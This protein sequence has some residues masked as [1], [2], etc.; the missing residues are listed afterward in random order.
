[1][2][3]E[4]LLQLVQILEIFDNY[5][6]IG[7]SNPTGDE[8]CANL[9]LKIFL[10][11]IGKEAISTSTN[12]V[13]E[14]MQHLPFMNE[15][16]ILTENHLKSYENIIIVD[17]D[18]LG[19]INVKGLEEI[20]RYKNVINIDHHIT[21]KLF[22]KHNFIFPEASSTTEIIAGLFI[23]TNKTE[24]SRDVAPLLLFGIAADTGIFRYPSVTARTFYYLSKIKEV[25]PN[26]EYYL[27]TLKPKLKW[28]LF[29]EFEKLIANTYKEGKIVYTVYKDKKFSFEEIKF[30]IGFTRSIEDMDV[31]VIFY[32]GEGEVQLEIRSK[33]DI[34]VSMVANKFG[35][36][37]HKNASGCILKTDINTAVSMVV[38]ELKKLLG[39]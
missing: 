39:G 27:N 31:Y 38:E 20:L 23:E 13:P 26:H 34:D 9:S 29:K 35:G 12:P 18:N 8:L 22:G 32:E 7:H 5:L 19:R 37:G 24:I 21:N 16:E 15:V 4:R 28:E 1:M 33:G 25:L 3:K 17:C 6:I 30:F 36:G 11:R 2:Y 10:E 14:H